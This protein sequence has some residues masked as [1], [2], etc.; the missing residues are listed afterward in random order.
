LL[1]RRWWVG[2]CGAGLSLA[3]AMMSKGPVA[4]L[5][6]V[7]PLGIY[8]LIMPR[9]PGPRSQPL[10]QMVMGLLIFVVAGLL[11]YALVLIKRPDAISIWQNELSGYASAEEGGKPW[12]TYFCII[13]YMAPWIAFFIVALVAAAARKFDDQDRIA[14][15]LLFVPLIVMSF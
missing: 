1:E 8:A 13:P 15:L 6:S 10:L 11:W 7:I 2:L 12:Y 14:L 4:L 5:Q 3:L 9:G